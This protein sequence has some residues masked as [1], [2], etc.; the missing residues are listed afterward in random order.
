MGKIVWTFLGPREIQSWGGYKPVPRD[1]PRVKDDP[2]WKNIK[3]DTNGDIIET[4]EVD[5]KGKAGT[6]VTTPEKGTGAVDPGVSPV[7][8]GTKRLRSGEAIPGSAMNPSGDTPMLLAAAGASGENGGQHETQMSPVTRWELGYFTETRSTILPITYYFSMNGLNNYDGVVAK[9]R[10]NCPY[11]SL[12]DNTFVSQTEG[13]TPVKGLSASAA[14]LTTTNPTPLANFPTTL[15]LST[16]ATNSTSGSGTVTA[17]NIGPAWLAWYQ[18]LYEAYSV[19]KTE[20]NIN[21]VSKT[22]S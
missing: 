14:S 17:A 18:K 21:I 19:I 13:S 4:G 5:A 6:M 10:L 3:L 9:I 1:D 11:N 7:K 16:P 22:R 8:Q 12:I 20:Y 2:R 15:T